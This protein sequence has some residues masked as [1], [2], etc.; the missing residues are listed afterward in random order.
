MGLNT[1][2]GQ[3]FGADHHAVFKPIRQYER[4]WARDSGELREL[5]V[6]HNDTTHY[7]GLIKLSSSNACC[8]GGRPCSPMLSLTKPFGSAT[9]ASKLLADMERVSLLLYVVGNTG[10]NSFLN[11]RRRAKVPRDELLK[12][13]STNTPL[14]SNSPIASLADAVRRSI[15]TSIRRYSAGRF[16]CPTSLWINLNREN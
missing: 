14:R 3:P 16:S 5:L 9:N 13:P 8:S 7:A 15:S 12:P 2:A 1:N 11:T 10:V 4:D 6:Y